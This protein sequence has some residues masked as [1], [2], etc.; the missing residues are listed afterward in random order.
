M[1]IH[2]LEDIPEQR[3]H[4]KKIILKEIQK[5][6]Y[7]MEIGVSEGDPIMFME[8]I[9]NSERS[10][11][12]LDILIKD[13]EITGFDVAKEIR[14]RHQ[15]RHDYIIFI[16]TEAQCALSA[17]QYKLEPLG[18]IL[19]DFPNLIPNMIGDCLLSVQQRMYD[20]NRGK[21]CINFKGVFTLQEE[22]IYIHTVKKN[23]IEIVETIDSAQE[24]KGSIKEVWENAGL[25][26]RFY[27]LSQ[28]MIINLEQ[29]RSLNRLKS[30]LIM[31]NGYVCSIPFRHKLGFYKQ[32]KDFKIN[33]HKDD[34]L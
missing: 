17:V 12:L 14:F 4:F 31:S 29:I 6:G 18:Y 2:I 21:A 5:H 10:I 13:M 20:A 9:R 28:S 16:T 25:D 11:F 34:F 15:N 22:I 19:K 30:E 27:Y 33:F 7:E 26:K 23:K 8:K 1:K 24:I 3:E 32:F